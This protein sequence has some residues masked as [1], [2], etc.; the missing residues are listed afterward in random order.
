MN[1]DFEI[2]QIGKRRLLRCRIC[3]REVLTKS[4]GHVRAVCGAPRP[5]PGPGSMLARILAELGVKPTKKCGCKKFAAK[6]D[7]LGVEGCQ[8]RRIELARA[9]QEKSGEFGLTDF[10]SAGLAVIKS[11]MALRINPLNPFLSLVDLAIE[12]ATALANG[13]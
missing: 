5:P 11:G 12:R 8:A 10:L 4:T 2:M 1:C 13:S 6:M 3:R 7:R 9:L